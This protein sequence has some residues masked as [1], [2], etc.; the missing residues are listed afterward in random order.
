[1]NDFIN[2]RVM[3]VD[4]NNFIVKKLYSILEVFRVRKLT[5]CDTLEE[6]E[7]KYYISE[8]EVIFIDFMMENRCGLGFLKNIRTSNTE[9]KSSDIPVILNTG[10]TDINTITMAR[11][12]GVTEVIGKPFSPDQVHQKLHN[13]LSNKRD[14]ISVD[15]YIGPNRRRKQLN[16]PEWDGDNERRRSATNNQN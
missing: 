11:D 14:F 9:K 12:S 10:I 3:I 5:I 13:A 6:A 4:N 8:L 1:M 15:D 16:N 7:K 2:L